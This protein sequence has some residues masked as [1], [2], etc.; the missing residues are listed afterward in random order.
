MSEINLTGLLYSLPI[1]DPYDNPEY[2]P[3]PLTGVKIQAKVINFI[4]EVTGSF[5]SQH[6]QVSC[7]FSCS[8]KN[9]IY[10]INSVQH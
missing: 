7:F 8:E 9:I 6:G 1:S 5:K 10:F 4:T 3:V 2:I